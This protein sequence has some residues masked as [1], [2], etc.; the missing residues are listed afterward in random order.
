METPTSFP[1]APFEQQRTDDPD[2]DAYEDKRARQ[3]ETA[4]EQVYHCTHGRRDGG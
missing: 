1:L 4:M 2:G 3:I